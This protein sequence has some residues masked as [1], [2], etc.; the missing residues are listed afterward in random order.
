MT[1]GVLLVG[2][3]GSGKTWVQ[4]RLVDRHGFWAPTHVTTRP[5]DA[6]DFGTTHLDEEPFL[7]GVAAGTLAAPMRFGGRWH[8]WLQAD[9]T[10]LCG[11]EA[12]AAVICRPYEALLLRAVQP[13]LHPIWLTAPE[14][15][16][17]ARLEARARTGDLAHRGARQRDDDDDE[18]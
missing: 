5:V 1:A 10:R 6:T 16:V 2:S 4:R 11:G 18:R 13:R 14:A 9:F 7:A 15:V 8:A 17:A 3:S 12:R